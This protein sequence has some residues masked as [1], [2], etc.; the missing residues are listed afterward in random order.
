MAEHVAVLQIARLKREA[1]THL[2]R[3]DIQGTEIA[4][5]GMRMELTKMRPDTPLEADSAHAIG[6]LEDLFG[7][8]KMGML[9]KAA[10]A[11]SNLERRSKP[12]P[13]QP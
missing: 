12:T 13:E 1:M 2:D 3:H 5:V 11:Q 6:E 8:G 9:R 4:L 7:A 10:S